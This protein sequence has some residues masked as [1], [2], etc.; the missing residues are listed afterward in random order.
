MAPTLGIAASSGPGGSG[1]ILTCCA[2]VRTLLDMMQGWWRFSGVWVS[3]GVGGYL[4]SGLLTPE[5]VD[6]GATP[7]LYVPCKLRR[8]ALPVRI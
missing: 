6:C 2:C 3:S 1:R 5:S 8:H 7:S 4:T